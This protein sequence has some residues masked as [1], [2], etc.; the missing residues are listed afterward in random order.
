VTLFA[1]LNGDS[2][3]T[4]FDDLAAKYPYP[5]LTRV[6]L[7]VFVVLFI[8]AILNTFIFIIEDAYHSAK[9]WGFVRPPFTQPLSLFF[10]QSKTENQKNV[11]TE[12]QEAG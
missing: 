9:R 12:R 10:F 8:T 1:L 7:F 4:I 5:L 11:I 3:L 2:I 6:Y